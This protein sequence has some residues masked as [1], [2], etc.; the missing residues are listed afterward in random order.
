MRATTLALPLKPLCFM[1]ACWQ[2]G[3]FSLILSL[4][5]VSRWQNV[6]K[7]VAKSASSF[8][9]FGLRV[10]FVR[11]ANVLGLVRWLARTYKLLSCIFQFVFSFSQCAI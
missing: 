8:A 11:I 7:R 3:L 10:G 9:I 6:T 1:T 4:S 2:L 5:I